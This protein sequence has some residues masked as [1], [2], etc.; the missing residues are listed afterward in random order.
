MFPGRRT[1]TCPYR[2]LINA[3]RLIRIAGRTRNGINPDCTSSGRPGSRRPMLGWS[4]Q[5]PSSAPRTIWPDSPGGIQVRFA[6]FS[7]RALS[8]TLTR[9]MTDMAMARTFDAVITCWSSVTA[10]NSKCGSC[11]SAKVSDVSSI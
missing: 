6:S 10:L 5:W 11:S 2:R 7:P 8:S 3:L 4:K 9:V 1:R